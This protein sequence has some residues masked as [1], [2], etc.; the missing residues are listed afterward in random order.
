MPITDVIVESKIKKSF[1][2]D[3]L[4]S[5]F[6]LP[7]ENKLSHNWHIELPIEDSEWQVGIITGPSGSGKSTIAKAIFGDFVHSG[8]AWP[9]DKAVVD[10]FPDGEKCQDIVSALNSVGFSS[11]S[12]WLKPF[13]V[14]SNG[15]KFRCELAR[16][17]IE[18]KNNPYFVIDEFTSVVDRDVAK[19]G[20]FAVS[21]AVRRT[22][23][24][25]IALSCHYDIIDWL[26]P[27]WVFDMRDLSFRRGR[28]RRPEIKLEINTVDRS[29]WQIF[30]KHH[31]LS[32]N[33][34]KASQCYGCFWKKNMVAFAAI[35]PLT[36]FKNTRRVHRIVVLPDYQGCGIAKVFLNFLGRHYRNNGQSLHITSSHPAVIHGLKRS[37]EWKAIAF[38]K[39][40][41]KVKKVTSSTGTDGRFGVV[42]ASFKYN[43]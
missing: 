2:V 32:A 39:F 42:T 35:L 11:P 17:I 14:L 36:G 29:L 41:C 4:K 31:Y 34:H 12:S 1:R 7:I 8:F 21:K 10:A 20:S 26:E 30:S 22:G 23:G 9:S 38:K 6:D 19:I 33:L 43:G 16:A 5:M 27:D 28:L 37:V 3:Q 18:Y 25:L 13:N 24:K 40:G 15:E